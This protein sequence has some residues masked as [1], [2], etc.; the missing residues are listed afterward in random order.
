[1]LAV[2]SYVS[3]YDCE[4]GRPLVWTVN[5]DVSASDTD[6]LTFELDWGDGNVSSTSGS[7]YAS[8]SR[9]FGPGGYNIT[10]R[11][12]D[13]N[14][15]SVSMSH[16]FALLSDPIALTADGAVYQGGACS[17]SLSWGDNAVTAWSIDWGDGLAEEMGPASTSA[18]H[19]YTVPGTY[20]VSAMATLGPATIPVG[21]QSVTV[22]ALPAPT[23]LTASA[24]SASRV[25]L[26]WS[27]GPI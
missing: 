3:T 7:A 8:F 18:G 23:S 6:E 26:N 13:D 16:A 21:E 11:V 14:G 5:A 9:G 22:E 27:D 19:V 17:A 12:T 15:A 4:T 25:D 10:A 20:T 2:C 24:I 1:M